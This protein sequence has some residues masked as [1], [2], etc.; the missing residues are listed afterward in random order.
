M[1]RPPQITSEQEE[2]SLENPADL[3]LFFSYA[4][5]TYEETITAIDSAPATI[6]KETLASWRTDSTYAFQQL[7]EL[8]ETERGLLEHGDRVPDEAIVRLQS[9]YDTIDD[10]YLKV[11]ETPTVTEIKESI[12]EETIESA[13]VLVSSA[14]EPVTATNESSTVAAEVPVISFGRWDGLITET[15]K[16]PV[17][18]VVS[19][20]NSLKESLLPLAT[21]AAYLL[22][23]YKEITDNEALDLEPGAFHPGQNLYRQ[24]DITAKRI[25]NIEAALSE[26]NDETNETRL[27]RY[28]LEIEEVKTNLEQFEHTLPSFF[29]EEIERAP[30]SG[31]VPLLSGEETKDSVAV[32]IV[33]KDIFLDVTVPETKNTH[34]AA[35]D[36]ES[37]ALPTLKRI[38]IQN[39]MYRSFVTQAY[40]SEGNLQI[41]LLR[42][43]E[44]LEKESKFNQMLGIIHASAFH[45]FLK[46][47]TVA[48]L[49]RFDAQ[50]IETIKKQLQNLTE[51]AEAGVS[52]DVY[53]EWMRDFARF[54]HL[55]GSTVS[56]E[57]LLKLSF[58][59]LFIR[60]Y[61]LEQM[62]F[63]QN[64]T[65][66]AA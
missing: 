49:T 47:K 10:V 46:D 31:T 21:Q 24:L 14:A 61:L 58:E 33:I 35:N 65:A 43:I 34:R 64:T 39:P 5:N 9:L 38:L 60:S 8:I 56:P 12:L 32:P 62:H 41:D 3:E 2:V 29:K 27:E 23:K 42:Y 66:L 22:E 15:R 11:T 45:T 36:N 44:H 17:P 28:S 1:E 55:V 57:T 52:Y 51:Y 18:E 19:R 16:D 6:P 54:K 7:K 63:S 40:I 48:E 30:T 50:P 20:I 13:P 4:K 59:E 53:H 26:E 25:K 37:Y